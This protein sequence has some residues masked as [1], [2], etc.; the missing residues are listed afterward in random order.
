M[1]LRGPAPLPAGGGFEGVPNIGVPFATGIGYALTASIGDAANDAVAAEDIHGIIHVDLRGSTTMGWYGGIAGG[2]AT[3][4]LRGFVM[5][6]DP[7][8]GGIPDDGSHGSNA[9]AALLAAGNSGLPLHL[10]GYDWF[11][12][13]SMWPTYWR[14]RKSP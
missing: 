8:Y 13:A 14:R 6:N 3:Q 9:A 5:P 7:A 10:G 11:V 1:F 12:D 4:A 2:G